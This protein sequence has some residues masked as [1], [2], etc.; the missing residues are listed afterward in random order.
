MKG[1]KRRKSV[2]VNGVEY[3]AMMVRE[4]VFRQHGERITMQAAWH[5]M[6]RFERS[7]G[8]TERL[9]APVAV[10]RGSDEWRAMA[11]CSS[12]EAAKRLEAIAHVQGPTA[13]ERKLHGKEV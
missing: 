11:D 8:D 2:T 12:E 13:I 9:F 3:T 10:K 7:G 5:R 1:G 4:E 6:R